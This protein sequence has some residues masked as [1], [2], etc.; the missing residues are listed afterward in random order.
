MSLIKKES[1]LL[2]FLG[3]LFIFS[4]LPFFVVSAQS[5]YP[6]PISGACYKASETCWACGIAAVSASCPLPAPGASINAGGTASWRITATDGLGGDP[7][8]FRYE[9]SDTA[10]HTSSVEGTSS[11]NFQTNTMR[12][13]TPGVITGTGTVTDG[14]GSSYC[15]ASLTVLA[16]QNGASCTMDEQCLSGY[17]NESGICANR[18]TPT[19][20][21]FECENCPA[22]GITSGSSASLRWS[23]E[24]VISC[25][26]SPQC[27]GSTGAVG[28]CQTS[29]LTATRSYRLTCQNSIG[30]TVTADATV[31][32]AVPTACTYTYTLS[33]CSMGKVSRSN[34]VGTPTGC[35]GTPDLSDQSQLC[36]NGRPCANGNQCTSGYCDLTDPEN[37][38]CATEPDV[39]NECTDGMDNDSDGVVDGD[40]AS[41]EEGDT[42]EGLNPFGYDCLIS[43][44]CEN[45]QQLMCD[46][47]D[48]ICVARPTANCTGKCGGPN[49][50]GGTCPNTCASSQ[51]CSQG[52][53]YTQCV[54][55]VITCTPACS[56]GQTCVNGT[57][58]P[59]GPPTDPGQFPDPLGGLT[60][61]QFV[62]KLLG[63]L[64]ELLI[65]IIV[66]FFLIDG[67]LFVTAR[68]NP[69]KLKIART[70]FLYTIIGTALV[71][72]A[73][74]LAEMIDSTIDA[75]KG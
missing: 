49:G 31:Q 27:S 53:G 16:L 7:I 59:S 26:V 28:A 3:I 66:I 63:V 68:G 33:E 15:T 47:E 72:G 65:P 4:F 20:S 73:W 30:T 62:G 22:N 67:L 60:L 41:C 11:R 12:Y 50:I 21:E 55:N 74:V 36:S 38:V 32:V 45:P 1:Y 64:V 5:C 48:K 18:P 52:S 57:C 69:E 13:N 37:G 43:D 44:D 75:V 17:C 25:S 42:V 19:I 71:L 51:T 61:Y 24:N 8:T 40:E 34:A 70:A 54:N 6:L 9:W 35:V 46:D 29:S 58:R 2:I 56:S 39:P 14:Y 23:A 10:G